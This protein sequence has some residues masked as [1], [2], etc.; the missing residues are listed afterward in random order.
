MQREELLALMIS[1]PA[2]VP[3]LDDWDRVLSIFAGYLEGVAPK[4][5]QK[6]LGDFIGAGAMFYRTLRQADAYRKEAV[7]ERQKTDG[8]AKSVPAVRD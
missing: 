1:V 4:L 7:W 6:E 8:Q 3:R 2:P 5:S